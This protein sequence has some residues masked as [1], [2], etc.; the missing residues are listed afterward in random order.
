M[1]FYYYKLFGGDASTADDCSYIT[2]TFLVLSF[3]TLLS[4]IIQTY[5]AD[6]YGLALVLGL[7]GGVSN[8]IYGFI[9]PGLIAINVL[10]HDSTAYKTGYILLVFGCTI[11]FLVLASIVLQYSGV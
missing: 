4:N 7:T 11:P 10:S 1:R 3:A 6:S 9:L 8:S 5:Y 2:S